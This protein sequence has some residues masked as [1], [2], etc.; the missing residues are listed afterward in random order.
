MGQSDVE[1]YSSILQEL[2]ESRNPRAKELTSR[3]AA[4]LGINPKCPEEPLATF[5]DM[6]CIS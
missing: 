2:S 3:L 4:R 6:A 1:L 5:R